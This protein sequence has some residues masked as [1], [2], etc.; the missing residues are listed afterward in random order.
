M[1][2]QETLTYNEKGMADIFYSIDRE[3]KDCSPVSP[4]ECMS[5]CNIWKLR[6]E[7]RLLCEAMEN[8][9]FVKD[10]FNVLKNGTRLAIL[11]T[12]ARNR[13]SITRLQQELKKSGFLHSQET[14]LEEYL[15]PLLVVG[16]A[17]EAHDQFHATTFGSRLAE[18]VGNIPE[19]TEILPPHSECYE[20]IILKSLLDGPKTFEEIKNLVPSKIVSRILKRLKTVGLINTPE[21]R[22]YVFFFRSRRDPVKETLTATE[23][24]VYTCIPDEGISAK[25]LAQRA[26][27]SVR[28]TYKYVR[29]L[30]GKKL[31]FARKS[32]KTYS[33]TEKGERL[34][35]LVSELQRIVEDTLSFSEEFAKYNENS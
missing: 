26:Q 19:F 9:Y 20:E 22:D 30:K 28:R 12:I 18:L 10:L 24:S 27:L 31:V 11:K 25:K 7:L 34:A 29:G 4:L 35:W 16:L 5:N 15:H 1:K 17:V 32:P 23:K 33:L 14:L 13:Y 3:C 2:T 21:E 6:N 8:P